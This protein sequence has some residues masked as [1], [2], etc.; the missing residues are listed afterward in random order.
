MTGRKN[1]PGYSDKLGSWFEG[2]LT[3]FIAGDEDQ[4]TSPIK[5]SA[6]K[7]ATK[8]TPRGPVGPFSHFSTISP[9]VSGQI[10]RVP[11]GVDFPAM[12]GALGLQTDPLRTSP[13]LLQGSWGQ[14]L[15]PPSDSRSSSSSYGASYAPEESGWQGTQS[16]PDQNEVQLNGEDDEDG[17]LNPMAALRLGP[18]PD[19]SRVNYQPQPLNSL[20][21]DDDDLGFSNSSL[22]RTRTPKPATDGGSSGSPSPEKPDEK[23]SKKEDPAK[24]GVK[25]KTI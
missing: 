1:K 9:A 8:H 3:K 2:R 17:L 25:S 20:D 24:P 12:N 16:Q 19:T 18:K 13:A 5:Q 15:E 22:S 7:S 11:S 10:S 14:P 6:P 21:D 4:A 23:N